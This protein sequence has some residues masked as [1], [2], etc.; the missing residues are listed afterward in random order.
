MLYVGFI[1]PK[2]EAKGVQFVLLERLKHKKICCGACN[3][4]NRT[5]EEFADMV[6][7]KHPYIDVIG[8]YLG[9]RNKIEVKCTKH[10]YSWSPYAYNLL[11]GYGCPMC[12]REQTAM[13]RRIP[14]SDKIKKL[15]IL[16]PDIEFL[17]TP[18]LTT[19]KVLCKCKICGR[20]WNTAYSNLS[21]QNHTNCPSCSSSKGELIIKSLLE[22][23]DIP[24]IQQYK[25][26]DLIDTFQLPFDFYLSS[27]NVLIE[28][29][30][31]LHYRPRRVI[32]EKKKDAYDDY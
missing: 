25:F 2:H 24:F 12:G 23:W 30:G 31:E 11:E 28:F 4:K 5:T 15:T 16:H 8:H 22:K 20:K 1:C 29:D 27:N 21:K 6:H 14:S 3:G 13:S 10:E 17:S 9:A 32:E 7:E 26:E 19:D 18:I